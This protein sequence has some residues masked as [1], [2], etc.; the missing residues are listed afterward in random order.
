M[1]VGF[2]VDRVDCTVL[3]YCIGTLRGC[4]KGFCKG[5]GRSAGLTRSKRR[6]YFHVTGSW[7][8]EFMEYR[9]LDWVL[10]AHTE[11]WSL[12]S[13]CIALFTCLSVTLYIEKPSGII[14]L[15]IRA[16]I[17]RLNSIFLRLGISGLGG[18]ELGL[19]RRGCWPYNGDSNYTLLP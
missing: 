19:C 17:I 16:S 1:G 8:Y 3:V 12:H 11:C 9:S 7:A 2:R 10:V 13:E 6:S 4:I 5:V 18:V 15:I 14:V